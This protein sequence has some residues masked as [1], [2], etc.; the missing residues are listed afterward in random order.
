MI[1]RPP[2]ST[3][4]PYTTLFRSPSSS[5]PLWAGIRDVWTFNPWDETWTRQPDTARGRWYPTQT[6]LADGRTL[7]VGGYDE[8]GNATASGGQIVDPDLEV[9]TPS[10]DPHG[11]G[12][13]H[14][15][16]SGE[17]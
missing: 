4:F 7:I 10:P 14:L 2:R 5:R 8:S 16:P 17:R 11:V 3:L 1:R 12:K 9:F 6:E 13:V 15:Y